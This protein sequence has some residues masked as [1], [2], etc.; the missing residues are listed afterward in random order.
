MDKIIASETTDEKIKRIR[1]FFEQLTFFFLF[2]IL[3]IIYDTTIH[4]IPIVKYTVTVFFM[5]WSISLIIQELYVYKVFKPIILGKRW[6]TFV[7][8]S[9]KSKNK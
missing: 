3:F 8:N 4:T 6:E 2:L 7:K 5:G 9:T 1:P